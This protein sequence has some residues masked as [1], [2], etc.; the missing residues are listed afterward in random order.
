MRLTRRLTTGLGRLAGWVIAIAI[1]ISL[2]E[3]TFT[4]APSIA[5]F[6]LALASFVA[7]VLMLALDLRDFRQRQR[8]D[9]WMT[10][11]LKR[12]GEEFRRLEE[13]ER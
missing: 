1:G 4:P 6:D 3:M 2:V 5:Q 9:P 13:A 10:P 12:L 7:V 11:S 8:P